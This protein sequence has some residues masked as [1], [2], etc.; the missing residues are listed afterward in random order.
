MQRAYVF[1]SFSLSFFFF[2]NRL[3]THYLQIK[4]VDESMEIK[5]VFCFWLDRWSQDRWNHVF[6]MWQSVYGKKWNSD[7]H[8]HTKKY[9]YI[10][11]IFPS[12]HFFPFFPNPTHDLLVPVLFIHS[13]IH[14][15]IYSFYWRRV[16]RIA[17]W[18]EIFGSVVSR[19]NVYI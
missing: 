1:L 12:S 14:S 3:Q 18:A 17:R 10:F 2:V 13:F 15:F 6:H 11:I 19:N 4:H 16:R 8:T 5:V 7:T 9:I